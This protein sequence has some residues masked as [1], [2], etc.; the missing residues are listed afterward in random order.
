MTAACCVHYLA[1]D[2]PRGQDGAPKDAEVEAIL[3]GA[4]A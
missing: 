2:F 4:A 3:E 1:P